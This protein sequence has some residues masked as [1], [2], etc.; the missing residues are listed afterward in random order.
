MTAFVLIVFAVAA[1]VALIAF[2]TTMDQATGEPEADNGVRFKI[3]TRA[4][5]SGPFHFVYRHLGFGVGWSWTSEYCSPNMEACERYVQR[6]KQV[7]ETTRY[8]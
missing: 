8:L 1:L 3:E 7:K 6:A 2:V 4:T 5:G